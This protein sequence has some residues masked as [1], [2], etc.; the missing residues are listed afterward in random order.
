MSFENVFR[1]KLQGPL[2]H[3]LLHASIHVIILR[4]VTRCTRLIHRER[5]GTSRGDSS[6]GIFHLA[7]Q[8]PKGIS[9]GGSIVI[10]ADRVILL[11][12]LA[13]VSVSRRTRRPLGERIPRLFVGTVDRRFAVPAVSL[14][15]R[16]VCP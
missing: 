9:P 3:A 7:D 6:E 10:L 2:L 16:K 8:S 4:I 13:L 15:R 12:L 14:S 11:D 5:G 1:A